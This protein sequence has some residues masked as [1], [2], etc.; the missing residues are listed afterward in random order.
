MLA[1][2]LLVAVLSLAM[3]YLSSILFLQTT[4]PDYMRENQIAASAQTHDYFQK[5]YQTHD[6]RVGADQVDINQIPRETTSR[7]DLNLK[8]A[9]VDTTGTVLFSENEAFLGY[10]V[11]EIEIRIQRKINR[12]AVGISNQGPGIPEEKLET[13]FKRY[14]RIPSVEKGTAE[15]LGLGLAISK[16][17]V[18]GHGGTLYAQNSRE[19]GA[20]FV[21]ELP[22][23]A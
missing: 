16:R 19:G 23:P 17:I 7:E 20:K 1:S 3:A 21:L 14:Y 6:G 15:G 5:Y 13:I 11:A 2:Y 8:L 9:L 4:L 22:Y 10:V 18:D 12:M